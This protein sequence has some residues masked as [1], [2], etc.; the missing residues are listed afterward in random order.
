MCDTVFR[1]HNSYLFVDFQQI[2][3]I[4]MMNLSSMIILAQLQIL[5]TDSNIS[6]NLMVVDSLCPSGTRRA[7]LGLL[8]VFV[9]LSRDVSLG[10]FAE[11]QSAAFPAGILFS[12]FVRLWATTTQ[13]QLPN[14]QILASFGLKRWRK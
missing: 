14:H 10:F 2:I 7:G 5:D 13:T 1:K 8:I 6:L 9:G 3:E 11:P 4:A 12:P